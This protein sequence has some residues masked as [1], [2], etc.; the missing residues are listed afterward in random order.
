MLV[1]LAERRVLTKENI[2]A[3]C[4]PQTLTVSPEGF[5]FT[6]GDGRSRS[7]SWKE[8]VKVGT[9]RSD[10][11]ILLDE[12]TALVVPLRAFRSEGQR[13]LFVSFSGAW[14]AQATGAP[15]APADGDR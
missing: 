15:E 5:E 6:Y 9:T 14:H 10:F 2:A 13:S 11:V 12:K 8:V 3:F 7:A 4:V 1:L